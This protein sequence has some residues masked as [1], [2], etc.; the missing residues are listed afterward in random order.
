MNTTKLIGLLEGAGYAAGGTFA[1]YLVSNLGASGA[2]SGL[3]LVVVSAILSAFD[4]YINKKNG[5][6]TAVFGMMNRPNTNY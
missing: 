2:L 6:A 4:D 3:T 1:A 5:G